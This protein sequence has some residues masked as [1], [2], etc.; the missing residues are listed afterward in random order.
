MLICIKSINII[1]FMSLPFIVRQHLADLACLLTSITL[2]SPPFHDLP[3][4]LVH[5]QNYFILSNIQTDNT[6]RFQT[7]IL[8]PV[9]VSV[10]QSADIKTKDLPAL[11][12]P[13]SPFLEASALPLCHRLHTK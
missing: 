3:S 5:T 12:T 10:S 1:L 6:E 9:S 7:R 11:S 8:N 4:T 13:P 2:R